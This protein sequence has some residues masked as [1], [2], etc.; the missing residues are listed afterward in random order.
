MKID[1]LNELHLQGWGKACQDPKLVVVVWEVTLFDIK[2]NPCTLRCDLID[3]DSIFVIGFF[4]GR[5][6]QQD[7]TLTL[8]VLRSRHPLDNSNRISAT[9]MSTDKDD[10]IIDRIIIELLTHPITC[11]TNLLLAPLAD[12]AQREP[13]I[14]AKRIIRATHNTA[15]QV[16]IIWRKAGIMNPDLQREMDKVDAAWDMRAGLGRSITTNKVSLSKVNEELN[17]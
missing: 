9:Y 4:V 16:S 11:I 5:L 14:F 12:H 8:P 13:R 7:S 1:P 2:D 15:T 17:I 3:G 6:S 10:P